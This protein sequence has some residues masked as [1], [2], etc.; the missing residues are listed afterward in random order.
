[1]TVAQIDV[2]R[3]NAARRDAALRYAALGWF[4][5]PLHTPSK[6]V[7]SCALGDQCGSP[8][9]HPRL[10]SGYK[11]TNDETAIRDLWAQFPG[12]NVAVFPGRSDLVVLDVDPRNGGDDSL[13]ELRREDIFPD[14]PMVHTGGGGWHYYFKRP[15]GVLEL[16]SGVLLPG[17]EVKADKGYVVAPPSMHY[18][19]VP[20]DWDSGYD[21]EEPLAVLPGWIYR[22]IGAAQTHARYSEFN[23]AGP[24]AGLMGAAFAALGAVGRRLGPDK[25]AVLCPWRNEHSTGKD[26]DGSTIVFAPQLGKA[27]GWFH[28]SHAH[29][30]KRTQEQVLDQLPEGALDAARRSLGM[31]PGARPSSP[32][33]IEAPTRAAENWMSELRFNS[34]GILTRDPGNAALILANDPQWHEVLRY[35]TM[36]ER[37]Q[38]MA[39]PPDLTGLDRPSKGK[40]FG[41]EDYLYIQHWFA[42]K[43][44]VTFS[45]DAIRQAVGLATRTNR[46]DALEEYLGGLQWDRRPRVESWLHTY[47]GA[48]DD[49]YTRFVGQAWLVSAVARAL[50][51]GCQADHTLVLEGPQGAGKS[52]AL[53][54]L[55]DPWFLPEL[56]PVVSKDALVVLLGMWIVNIEELSGITGYSWDKVKSFLTQRTDIFRKPYGEIAQAR[57]RR[58]VFSA[59]TNRS[60]YATDETGNR[61][62]WPVECRAISPD[63]VARDRDQIWA[64]AVALYRAGA[65]WWPQGSELSGRL[66]REQDRRADE[67]PWFDLIIGALMRDP[68]ARWTTVGVLT[69]IGCDLGKATK[70]ESRRVGKVMRRLYYTRQTGGSTGLGVTWVPPVDSDGAKRLTAILDS[71]RSVLVSRGFPSRPDNEDY[72]H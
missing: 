8:G 66:R 45:R 68:D 51:P 24:I 65:A 70:K 44:G 61:R 28:C 49:M 20:Y 63:A 10:P 12:A 43:R 9:K 22:K 40:L 52:S 58:C 47:L 60:D 17:L 64:E 2:A 21:L 34:K 25:V 16:R 33:D 50:E 38:W 59:T 54:A 55:A 37:V 14:T 32:T 56:P 42:R 26:Y 18:S 3:E 36:S 41:E 53:R 35:E 39:H 62:L 23:P 6:G 67:D 57:Q 11:P 48:P 7:C 71:R 46:Y 69:A 4:V 1:M 19:G 27:W 31:D 30:H 13:D 15:P 72:N 29:C 5:A